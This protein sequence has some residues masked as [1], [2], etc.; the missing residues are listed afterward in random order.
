MK[1]QLMRL[2]AFT[3]VALVGLVPIQG[4]SA[5]AGEL[6]VVITVTGGTNPEVAQ[7]VTGHPVTLTA[8]NTPAPAV[9]TNVNFDTDGNVL[10]VDETCSMLANS[11]TCSVTITEAADPAVR[12]WVPGETPACSPLPIP[13]ADCDSSEGQDEAAE[14]GDTVE[15]DD[16]DVVTV[17]YLEGTLDVTP[18]DSAASPTSPASLTAKVVSTE[19]TPRGLLAN[20]DM[21]II[22]GPNET[23]AAGIDD[24]CDTIQAGTCTLTYTPGATTGVDIV[25]SWIDDDNPA[26]TPPTGDE[27]TGDEYEADATEET[28]EGTTDEPDNTDTVTVNVS[29]DPILVAAPRTQP[30]NVTETATITATLTDDG[31]PEV[32]ER[33]SATVLS[34]GPNANKA[35][36]CNTGSGGTCTIQ[37][38]GTTAGTDNVRLWADRD[39]DGQPDEADIGETFGTAGNTPEGDTTMVVQVVWTGTTPPPTPDPD[40][41]DACDQAKK[42]V[43]RAKKQLKKAKANGDEGDIKKAKRKL[44]RAKRKKANAC[45]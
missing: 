21:E 27:T 6:D 18:E 10:T 12:A 37:Y 36:S 1:K 11:G 20:V 2:L 7:V 29:P 30:K 22:E 16:T 32:G 17:E 5:L 40:D 8:T 23:V 41:N 31:T 42:N 44:A 24:E 38:T 14:A 43:K 35:L 25:R 33:I 19:T 45:G 34:G 13:D 3:T 4:A 9:A 26:A 28:V 39:G 15:P